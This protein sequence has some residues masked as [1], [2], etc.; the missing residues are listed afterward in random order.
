MNKTVL[1][2]NMKYFKAAFAV[3]LLNVLSLLFPYLKAEGIHKTGFGVAKHLIA[4]GNMGM[5]TVILALTLVAGVAVRESR[6][7]RLRQR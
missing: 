4:G 5:L 6:A 2:L 7:G 1:G 3:S